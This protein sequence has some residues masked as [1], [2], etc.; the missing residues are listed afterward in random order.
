MKDQGV[1][2][3]GKSKDC[4]FSEATF[5]SQP[6]CAFCFTRVDL[7]SRSLCP[8]CHVVYHAD[9]WKTNDCR[10]AVYGCGVG[11]PRNTA[12]SG[13][14]PFGFV[15]GGIIAVVLLV[16]ALGVAVSRPAMHRAATTSCM[17]NLC[18]LWRMQSVY[19]AQFGGP[20]KRMNDRTGG[21][22]WRALSTTQPPL[23]DAT[24]WDIY[25]CPVKGDSPPGAMDYW[26]PARP[27]GELPGGPVGGDAPGNHGDGEGG[28]LLLKS[29]DVLEVRERVWSSQVSFLKP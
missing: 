20:M 28:N 29:G 18:Q 22:F 13:V 6:S 14:L 16:A 15:L 11:I 4:D 1:S 24:T 19:A 12:G 23:I 2:G 17:N 10:C 7:E 3:P 27:V 9:C 5:P 21:E 8:I 26:G 25:L